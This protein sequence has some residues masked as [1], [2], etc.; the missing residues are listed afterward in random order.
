MFFGTYYPRG[1]TRFGNINEE[2]ESIRDT[3]VATLSFTYNFGN[4]NVKVNKNKGGAQDEK[5][6]V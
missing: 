5:K 4:N 6:R 1:Y 3:R 2:F